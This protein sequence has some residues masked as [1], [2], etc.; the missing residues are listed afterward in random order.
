MN[1]ADLLRDSA[2]RFPDK[3]ALWFRGR[4]ISY[5]D[6][7]D[8]VDWTASGLRTLGMEAGHRVALLAGNVPE[9]VSTMYGAMRAGVVACPLGVALT[10][11]EVGHI[12]ADAGAKVA[13]AEMASLPSLL[14]V[15][16]RLVDLS[17]VL[18]IG[19]PPVP[20]RTTPLDDVVAAGSSETSPIFQDADLALIAYT[21][22][23]T[24]APRGA[25]LSHANLL[26][27]LDQ[28]GSVRDLAVTDEDV[29]LLALPLFHIYGLNVALGL[30]VRAGATGVLVDRFDARE[31]LELIAQLGITV[32]FGAPPM[33]S[34]WL[35]LAEAGERAAPLSPKTLTAF[36]ERFG[37]DIWEGYGLTECGPAVTS[38]AVGG[39]PKPGSIG[40]PLPG[41]E[42]RLVD[43]AG[44]D[45]EDGDPGEILVRGP[46]VFR[47]YWGR[48]APTADVLEGEWLRTGDV[49]YRDEDGYLFLV[50][51]KRDLI[52]VSG[53]NVYP[54][55]VEEAIGRHPKVAETAVVGIPDERTGEAVQA[56]IVPKRK[57]TV[58]PGE[59]TD[60]L[61]GYLARFKWPKDIRVVDALPHHVTGKVLRRALRDERRPGAAERSEPPSS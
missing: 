15:R 58:T 40:P 4:A 41:V 44:M 5:G 60:F 1:V 29:T 20:S 56:W 61:H 59:I 22:G 35:S 14:A 47:G 33:F 38:N 37:I 8:R 31:S 57:Q 10:P 34:A 36:R 50:D 42:V 9:F 49:A 16:D 6:L 32:V 53:F 18:A 23:T 45:A 52:T 51:R 43:E 48:H 12:L 25:K 28:M 24:G 19:G 26:A 7:D 13:V 27:N 2:R 21:S 55:E 54:N 3:C 17:S 11:E 39:S 46:N 30:T